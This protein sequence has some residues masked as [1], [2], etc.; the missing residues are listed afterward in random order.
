MRFSNWQIGKCAA[1]AAFVLP[2]IVGLAGCDNGFKS[3]PTT[4]PADTVTFPTASTQGWLQQFGTGYV[5][6]PPPADRSRHNG[7]SAYGEVTDFQGNVIVLDK[8]YGAFPGFSNPNN[9][10]EF[11]VAKFDNGGHQVWLQQFGTGMGDS[12]RAIATDAQGDI[13]V[14]G[15][16]NGAFPGFTNANGISESVVVKLDPAGNTLWIQQLSP[17]TGPSRVT[18]LATD[19]QGNV[20]VGGN[21]ADASDNG[22][23]YVQKLS[24]SNGTSLWTQGSNSTG[25]MQNISGVAVDG[26]DNVI[27]VGNFALNPSTI[28]MVA[29]LNGTNGQTIWQQQPV[30]TS[31][32][33]TQSAIYTQ[34]AVNAQGDIFVDGLDLS[35]GWTQC[36]VAELASGSGNTMWKQSFGAAQSC[37]PGGIATDP[38]GNVLISGGNLYP[39]FPSSSPPKT[40]DVFV[41]KLSPTG[42]GVWL[43][44]FGT[45]Q[46]GAPGYTNANAL[47]FVATDDQSHAYV[48]STTA[49]AFPGF[50]NPNGAFQV[51]VTQFGP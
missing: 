12:P 6:A 24:G 25:A 29:K 4:P 3:P 8:T 26:Q 11:V 30:T 19:S 42:S 41:A 31:A 15:S 20:I 45:G 1:S 17:S 36:T 37:I 51:F 50:T 27:A 39:F 21:D 7:D 44:Q 34:A 10:S 40:D 14:G 28:Y 32:Y 48:A 35:S 9:A 13:I 49:G 5:P 22:Y 38:S 46:E 47:V 18:G 2:V 33:G 23:G 16:T 43:Q